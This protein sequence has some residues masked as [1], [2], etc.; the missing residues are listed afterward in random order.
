MTGWAMFWYIVVTAA[1]ISYFGLAVVLT[2]GGFFDVKTMFRRLTDNK[3]AASPPPP[4]N[5][6]P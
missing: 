4:E 6:N 5:I 1:V 2:I 3:S